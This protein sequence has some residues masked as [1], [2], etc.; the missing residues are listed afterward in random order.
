VISWE[1]LGGLLGILGITWDSL[2]ASWG[3]A[4]GASW[5]LLGGPLGASGGLL[6]QL[7]Q[8]A[9]FYLHKTSLFEDQDAQLRL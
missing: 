9:L 2:G 7:V 6:Y 8:N 1:P 3:G 4:L 5:G